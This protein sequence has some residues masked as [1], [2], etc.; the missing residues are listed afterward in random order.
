[1]AD[2]ES[3]EAGI[4]VPESVTVET[5]ET[6]PLPEVSASNHQCHFLFMNISFYF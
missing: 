3:G 4:E 1:M 6:H 5:E 2:S